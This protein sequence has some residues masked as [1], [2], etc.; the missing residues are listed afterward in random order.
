MH[1]KE[2]LEEFGASRVPV[3][4]HSPNYKRS[5]AYGTADADRNSQNHNQIVSFNTVSGEEDN[6]DFYQGSFSSPETIEFD[7]NPT[8]MT[9][10]RKYGPS[11]KSKVIESDFYSLYDKSET[12]YLREMVD[13]KLAE[14]QRAKYI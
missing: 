4:E 9:L 12:S 11:I 6:I 2:K 10:P 1:I 3:T 7:I 8:Q 14:S 5:D 13:K